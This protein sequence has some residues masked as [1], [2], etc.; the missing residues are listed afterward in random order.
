MSLISR[1]WVMFALLRFY[2]LGSGVE[3]C[4]FA[5]GAIFRHETVFPWGPQPNP[6]GSAPHNRLYSIVLQLYYR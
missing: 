5:A 6:H 3:F 2:A 1:G 4:G